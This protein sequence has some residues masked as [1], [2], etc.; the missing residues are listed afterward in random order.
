[1]QRD[2]LDRRDF[3]KTGTVAA[4]AAGMVAGCSSA[5]KEPAAP[6]ASRYQAEV[7]DTL[8]LAERAAL[9][10]NALTG[11]SDPEFKYET[12][13][14]GHL[15]HQPPFMSCL[16]NGPCLQKPIQA[17]PRLRIMSGSTLNSDTDRKMVEAVIGTL[18]EDGLWWLNVE[19]RPWRAPFKVDTSWPVAQGRL[20]VALLDWYQ[21][22]GDSKW[23]ELT[24][25][26]ADGLARIA[27]RNEDRAWYYTAY[28]RRGKW[29]AHF[30]PGEAAETSTDV[31]PST[32]AFYNVGLPLR[33]F[34]RWYA[35]SG[36]KKAL[37]MAHRLARFMLKPSMWG[38]KG[39]EMLVDVEHGRWEGHFHTHT[40]G[41]IG[42]LEY[43]VAVNDARVKRFVAE[44]Y[45]YARCFG[46]A[47]MG[48]FP[49]FSM[50]MTQKWARW[51]A[52]HRVK[53]EQPLDRGPAGAYPQAS[54]TCAV[55]DMINLAVRL[56]ETGIGDYWDDV[57][58]YVRN[59]LVES[60]LLRRDLLEEI[61]AAAPKHEIDPE[62]ETDE[63]VL[64]RNIGTFASLS[65]PAWLYA[66]WTMC[67]PGN[68][69]CALY[70]AWRSILQHGDGVVQVNLLLNRASPWID[71]DSYL[72]YQ[73]KVV[74]KNKTAQKAYVRIPLWA[75]KKAVRCQVNQRDVSPHWLNNYLIIE[76]LAA[77][78]VVAIEFPMV[79]STA[80]YTLP[81][82]RQQYTCHFKG[83]TLVDI[84]PRGGRPALAQM[85]SDDGS[86]FEI[87][88]GYPIYMRDHY[89]QNEAPLRRVQRYI[90][91]TLI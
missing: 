33:A 12:F 20:M 1:M 80:K 59:H 66:W 6:T 79:E 74:L 86:R 44:A 64:E 82:Y 87:N 4:V 3:V 34:S 52:E 73:G 75:D 84:S 11:A 5:E 83:N 22:D 72:P 13:Q 78:D 85:A 19:G 61:I 8:D 23:L 14:G 47:R 31:E 7:P 81:S 76:G 70:D 43:A 88:N 36:D 50:E 26:M 40:M 91:P 42:L 15:D 63:N 71:L 29:E 55:A 62:V 16:K 89:K 48:F 39:P 21:Y 58:Q 49:E 38:R 67:C 53:R 28:G 56:S 10:V 41:L 9:A 2:E 24:G 69:S 90:S 25:R 45:E 37:D 46:I 68:A 32:V 77:R 51:L 27:E 54:E 17:L 35:L 60:Q 30:F 57:D 65:D 18:E